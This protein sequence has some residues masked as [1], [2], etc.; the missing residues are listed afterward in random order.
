VKN[1]FIIITSAVPNRDL[2][3]DTRE[4]LFWDEHAEF[5]DKPV[6]EGFIFMGGPFG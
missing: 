4:Q 5:I 1:K 3:K 6:D 2:M